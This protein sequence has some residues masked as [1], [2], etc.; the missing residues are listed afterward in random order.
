MLDGYT[1]AD[2]SLFAKKEDFAH[3]EPNNVEAKANDQETPT[4]FP[5]KQLH[6]IIEESPPFGSETS[7]LTNDS[8][9]QDEEEHLIAKNVEE[10]QRENSNHAPFYSIFLNKNRNK[11]HEKKTKVEN[12]NAVPDSSSPKSTFSRSKSYSNNASIMLRNLI[13]CGGVDTNDSGMVMVNRQSNKSCSNLDMSTYK[14]SRGNK[15]AE[16]CRS[17]IV[18]GSERFSKVSCNQ[19]QQNPSR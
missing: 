8:T 2:P 4:N 19:P 7:T 6:E 10:N 16:I 11:I 12:C 18:G 14:P 9:K 1:F 5:T 13:T 3:K 15:M 17:E